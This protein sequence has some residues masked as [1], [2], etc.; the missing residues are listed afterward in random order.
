MKNR[1]PE[2]PAFLFP[3]VGGEYTGFLDQLDER[4]GEIL[5]E[6][7]QVIRQEIGLSLSGDDRS[8]KMFWDWIA[9]FTGDC[10]VYH[11][12]QAWGIKPVVM[13]G[14]SMGLITALVCGRAISF[15]NGLRLLQ[16]IYVYSRRFAGDNQGMGVIIG[17]SCSEVAQFIAHLR[18]ESD[19]YIAAENSDSCI[20]ISGL[21]AGIGQVLQMAGQSGA[22]KTAAIKAPNAF[23]SPRATGGIES[24][25]RLLDETPVRDSEI[26]LLSVYNQRII[27]KA[28]DLKSEL[29]LNMTGAMKWKDSIMQLGASGI[30]GFLEVSPAGELTRMSRVINLEFEFLTY[31]KI[32]RLQNS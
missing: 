24:L 14:Y 11:T 9:L 30:D 15:V 4:R 8:D 3:G 29:L 17:K 22:I 10:L 31:N 7:R 25:V 12:Y 2:K 26:P 19:V 1:L 23:H 28:S 21:T 27:Q 16:T 20:V 6:Y 13:L 5:Q 32:R 18:L